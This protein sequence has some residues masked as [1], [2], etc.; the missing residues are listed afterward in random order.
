VH[1]SFHTS[2]SVLEG[3]WEYLQNGGSYKL[4]EIKQAEERCIEFLL[5]HHLYLSHRTLEPVD[6]K[7]T[8]F[9]Y[10]P[11]WYYDVLKALYHLAER[12]IGYDPRLNEALQ[13]LNRKCDTDGRWKLQNRHAGVMPFHMEKVGHSSRWN[14]LRALRVLKQ[15]NRI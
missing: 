5:L 12:K 10:P 13:L 11:H 3:L 2:L 6:Y 7:K 8:L 14:T 9:S 1:G 4:A 15:F